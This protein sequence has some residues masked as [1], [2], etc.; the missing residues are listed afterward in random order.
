M[1]VLLIPHKWLQQCTDERRNLCFLFYDQ[2]Q[3]F[4]F[5]FFFVRS[6]YYIKFYSNIKTSLSKKIT[7]CSC[8]WI[9]GLDL[10][11]L[12]LPRGLLSEPKTKHALHS[13]IG[14][15]DNFSLLQ[16]IQ[17]NTEFLVFKPKS[18]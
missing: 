11:H 14:N 12:N 13:P 15:S 16:L 8:S 6:R 5:L 10:V 9:G 3:Q 2:L 4:F 1:H 18:L 7:L 17:I